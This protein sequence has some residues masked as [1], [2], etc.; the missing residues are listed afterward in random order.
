MAAPAEEKPVLVRALLAEHLAAVCG[1]D[2]SKVDPNTSIIRLGLDSLMAIELIN[3]VE[4]ELGLVL[5]M[6]KVISGPTLAELADIVVQLLAYSDD[7]GSG[8]G[9]MAAGD[10]CLQVSK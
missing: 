6:G 9:G 3:R 1:I 10:K 4:N 5:P 2:V 8:S 7:D